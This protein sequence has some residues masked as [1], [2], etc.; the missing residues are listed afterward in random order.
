MTD[1]REQ[2]AREWANERCPGQDET[3]IV[4]SMCADDFLAGCEH[5]AKRD[6]WVSVKERLPDNN[7]EVLAYSP[8]LGIGN[9]EYYFYESEQGRLWT[10]NNYDGNDGI[11]TFTFDVDDKIIPTHWQP[12]PNPPKEESE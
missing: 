2:A 3:D 12:L 10:L 5:E 7:D 9:W 11:E 8:V 4:W 1:E 6:R